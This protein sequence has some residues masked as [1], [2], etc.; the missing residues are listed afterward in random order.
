MHAEIFI[1]PI[2]AEIMYAALQMQKEENS[3]AL[4]TGM[5][6]THDAEYTD[7]LLTLITVQ[8]EI[9]DLQEVLKICYLNIKK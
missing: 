8:Q 7:N 2:Q 9:T 6:I 1:T 4:D 5:Y 3:V